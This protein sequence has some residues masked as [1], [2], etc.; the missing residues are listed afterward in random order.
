MKTHDKK[1]ISPR[2]STQ[3]RPVRNPESSNA[4][5]HPLWF[6]LILLNLAIVGVGSFE[7]YKSK[8]QFEIQA[9]KHTQNLSQVL[10]RSLTAL[11]DKIDLALLV[12][13]DEIERQVAQGRV[14][15]Q[16]VSRHLALMQQRVPDTFNLRVTDA[17]GNLRYGSDFSVPPAVN[18]AD[19]DY[20]IQ[21]RNNPNA[22]LFIA[23]PLFGKTSNKWLLTL[24]RR[25]NHADDSFYGVVYG[26]I[27]LEHFTRLFEV[28]DV[29]TYGTITLRDSEMGIITSSD[30]LQLTGNII[31]NK[32]FSAP[33]AAALKKNP[34]TGTYISGKT[35]I[36]RISRMHSYRMFDKYPLV[37]NTGL[38]EETYLAVWYKQIWETGAL[39]MAFMLSSAIFSFLI[40]RLLRQ[41]HRYQNEL[42]L[43][44]QV[45]YLTGIS[46]RGHFMQQAEL[47][48]A[49]AIRYGSDLSLF[50][51]DIDFFKQ[52]NDRHGHQTGDTVLKSLADTCRETLRE[53]DIIGRVGGE[54]F[55]ILLPETGQNKAFEVAER[56]RT[57]LSQLSVATESGVPVRFTVS[58]GIA[59]LMTKKDN[60]DALLSRAD[61]ALYEAKE[62]GRNKV[63]VAT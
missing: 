8:H 24:S 39:I 56:L 60:L 61:K 58:I 12:C 27:S 30:G 41:Q 9:A 57:A 44:A 29:G 59:F 26:T 50:M 2:P 21:Q 52:V 33:F 63:C 40:V 4:I 34:K 10:E 5:I 62:S 51:M 36:D 11:L 1:P 13:T 32:Q 3:T 38:T 20:F 25:V 14:D 22:G 7:L 23:K 43:K 16:Q 28:V 47:E 53:V 17:K 31:G 37:V 15:S 35:S 18:Y 48:R 19:R 55:A 45:D 46:N 54:E 49:R 42:V 6:G